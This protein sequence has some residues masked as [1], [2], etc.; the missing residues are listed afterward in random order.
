MLIGL[1]KEVKNEEYRIG[2]T[3]DYVKE[4]VSQGHEVLIEKDAGIG[5]QFT[6]EEYEASGAKIVNREEAWQADMIIKVKEPLE[7]E[8]DFLRSGQILYT[9]LH[10]AADEKLTHMLLEKKVTGVAYETMTDSSGHLP[11][12]SP[13][14]EIAGRLAMIEAAKCSQRHYGGQ[15]ILLSSIPG[16]E[17]ANVVVVGGGV[18]GTGAV[19]MALGFGANVTVLDIDVSRLSYLLDIFSGE[20]NT[21][22]SSPGNI[23]RAVKDA[24][25]VIGSVLVPGSKAP[26]LVT[27][28]DVAAMKPGAV[29]V[30]V[31][32]DQGGCIETSRP[33]THEDPVFIHEGVVH[34]CVTNM[35][36]S[37]ARTA[38]I[39]LTNATATWGLKIASM[40]IRDAALADNAILTGLNTFEGKVLCPGVASAFDL[41]YVSPH[42]VLK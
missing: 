41:D 16:V 7:S 31:A 6:N 15:G 42:D 10:L 30:D 17:R 39:A 34:Y 37:V 18:V 29:I 25:V 23:R 20:I 8:Y 28:E 24:D 9:Y 1:P 35:P 27:K 38:T 14:S 40:G 12:L 22:Y 36:S 3:P 21:M 19:R 32:I 13:M 33:T 11:S 26:K 2:L 5:A 4:Y